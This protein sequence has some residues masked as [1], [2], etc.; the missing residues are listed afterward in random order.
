MQKRYE[1]L[2][3]NQAEFGPG[4][5]VF[6]ARLAR[7][8]G[9]A[10]ASHDDQRVDHV[11]EADEIGAT[12]SEFPTTIEAATRARELDMMVIMGA[13]NLMRGGSYSGNVS[14]SEV[15][16]SDL[17]DVFASDYVPRSMIEAAFRLTEAPFGW[18]V[19]DAIRTVSANAAASVGMND[20]GRIE[21]GKQADF[22]RVKMVD[23]RPIVRGVWVQG[24]RVA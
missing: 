8:L 7:E 6:V 2:L 13:P 14:A 18:S 24:E 10:L 22:V 16:R 17:L 3:S 12:L 4:N 11:D 19:P 9:L 20:R 1:A 5:R 23:G 21:V 15:A